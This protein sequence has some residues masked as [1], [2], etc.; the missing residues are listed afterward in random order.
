MAINDI[1][2]A[3]FD[4]LLR[5]ET[6]NGS[7]V[8]NRNEFQ[9]EGYRSLANTLIYD[10]IIKHTLS[11]SFTGSADIPYKNQNYNKS[12]TAIGFMGYDNG[13]KFNTYKLPFYET[14]D[15]GFPPNF[16]LIFLYARIIP[17]KRY[18]SVQIDSEYDPPNK[19]EFEIYIINTKT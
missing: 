2:E 5:K 13:S 6:P 3:G 11:A 7:L 14:A 16:L 15:V 12:P 17:F 9:P 10:E 1:S 8:H 19:F 18:V 4:E